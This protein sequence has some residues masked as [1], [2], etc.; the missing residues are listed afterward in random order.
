MASWLGQGAV[1]CHSSLRAHCPILSGMAI[2]LYPLKHG[3]FQTYASLPEGSPP[4]SHGFPIV[5]PLN[6]LIFQHF[7]WDSDRFQGTPWQFFSAELRELQCLVVNETWIIKPKI[8]DSTW[9]LWDGRHGCVFVL[10]IH[11]CLESCAYLDHPG[12]LLGDF[13]RCLSQLKHTQAQNCKQ[14]VQSMYIPNI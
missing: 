4:F 8:L 3:D 14:K 6:M 9:Q 12:P 10:C 2:Y 5:Y 13:W 7:G 11:V 1:Q